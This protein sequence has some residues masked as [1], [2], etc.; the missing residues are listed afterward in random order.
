MSPSL[1]S[2]P[3]PAP[4]TRAG[5]KSRRRAACAGTAPPRGPRRSHGGGPP[6]RRHASRTAVCPVNRATAVTAAAAAGVRQPTPLARRRRRLP[7]PRGDARR[8]RMT[9]RGRDAPGHPPRCSLHAGGRA[10]TRETAR[11]GATRARGGGGGGGS[12]APSRCP[13]DLGPSLDSHTRPWTGNAGRQRR[14]ARF[15]AP[16]R[17]PGAH[18][19]GACPTPR[20]GRGRGGS[21]T[22][23]VEPYPKRA[24]ILSCSEKQ[25]HDRVGK[26]SLN[27]SRVSK[28]N[29]PPKQ[30]I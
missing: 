25:G 20:A 13:P 19:R 27:N 8:P 21:F 2:S 23:S 15:E 4:P 5:F 30:P 29:R 14:P 12:P 6:P 11:V 22:A 3:P 24:T 7:P 16:P 9:H 26:I 18:V 10:P 1:L 28:E 17:D